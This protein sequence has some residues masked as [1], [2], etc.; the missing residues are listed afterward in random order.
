MDIGVGD[1][2]DFGEVF[3]MGREMSRLCVGL[4]VL[5]Q[6]EGVGGALVESEGA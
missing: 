6:A 4:E 1:L 5:S 3:R 2:E